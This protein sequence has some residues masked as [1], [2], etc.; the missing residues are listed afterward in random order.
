MTGCTRQCF[1]S[2]IQAADCVCYLGEEAGHEGPGLLSVL[3]PHVRYCRPL[4]VLHAALQQHTA[5]VT[6]QHSSMSGNPPLGLQGIHSY[7]YSVWYCHDSVVPTLHMPC[8][9][10]M[11]HLVI[12]SATSLFSVMLKRLAYSMDSFSIGFSW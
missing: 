11:A 8:H 6:V 9:G 3:R 4:K 7:M 10:S 1:R 12:C 5:G 2:V